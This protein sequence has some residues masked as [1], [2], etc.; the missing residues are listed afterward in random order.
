[1]TLTPLQFH[2]LLPFILPRS[3]AGRQIGDLR[4]RMEAIFHLACTTDP[5]RCLPPEHGR[6][7]TVS[8]Y[9]R[10]LTHAGLWERLLVAIKDNDPKHPLNQI[11][12]LIFRACRRAVRLRGLKFVALIR[13]LG[14]LQALNGP[15]SK[16]PD[17]DLSERMRRTVWM[18][19][20]PE[21]PRQHDLYL[22]LVHTLRRMHRQA[23]GVI[24]IPRALRL[25]WS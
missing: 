24:H 23:S 6:P 20:A 7:D 11:A 16:V 14:F 19:P 2:A 21:T 5:W 8:R 1:M 3:P 4:A 13:R 15:P 18:P 25:G 22:D 10:R 17:P 9:F 12:P